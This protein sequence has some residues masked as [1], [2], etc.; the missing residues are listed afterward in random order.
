MKR[1]GKNKDLIKKRVES[2][3]EL[4]LLLWMLEEREGVG[5]DPSSGTICL[6]PLSEN[7][8]VSTQLFLQEEKAGSL[9]VM[10]LGYTTL[11]AAPDF[12]SHSL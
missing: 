11:P 10:T 7:G 12:S 2:P 5:N 3:K 8:R 9:A 4:S 6:C 1:E